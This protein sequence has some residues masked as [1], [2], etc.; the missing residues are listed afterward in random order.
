MYDIARVNDLL[1][2]GAQVD[3]TAKV[4]D[5]CAEWWVSPLF[6]AAHGNKLATVELLLRRGAD[7]NMA[8]Q[9]RTPLEIACWRRSPDARIVRVLLDAGARPSG[10]ALLEACGIRDNCYERVEIVEMLLRGGAPANCSYRFRNGSATPLPSRRS[11]LGG[12]GWFGRIAK[13]RRPRNRNSYRAVSSWGRSKQAMRKWFSNS[14]SPVKQV[15]ATGIPF[16]KEL[17]R[18]R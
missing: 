1:D 3:G 2:Q 6:S 18:N 10:L 5:G 17:G 9:W 16:A 7:P 4:T 14:A 8:P 11:H 15:A 13:K 12:R